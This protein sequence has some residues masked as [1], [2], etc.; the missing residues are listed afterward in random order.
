MNYL[1]YNPSANGGEG[2]KR[3]DDA[4]RELAARFPHFE[5]HNILTLN[6]EEF[7]PSLEKEDNVVLVGGDGTLNHFANMVY[8]KGFSGTFYL[9]RGG[10]GNDFARDVDPEGT[11]AAILL[12]PYLEHL[13]L[14]NVAGESYRFLNGIGFGIDG[15][16]YV[17][18]Q[19][20]PAGEEINYLALAR[21]E[22]LARYQPTTATVIV[23][24]KTYVFKRAYLASTMYGRAY[25]GG[26]KLA[27]QQKRDGKKL[28]F[29]VFSG[30]GRL[31]TLLAFNDILSG[32]HLK[33]TDTVRLL[34]G[35]KI[36]VSFA[37]PCAVQIDG[38]VL[39]NVTTYTAEL[40]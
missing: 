6:P 9:Y 40:D 14:V 33:H 32:N 23:D 13:P 1:L 10:N 39:E 16:M 36:T 21:K 37:R 12:N 27:P 35:R 19:K 28:S 5:C 2:E 11:K 15:E 4:K 7:F 17:L 18:A 3:K 25:G 34:S 24:G 26:L 8:D 29:V 20:Q 22:I 38:R 31:K 30:H